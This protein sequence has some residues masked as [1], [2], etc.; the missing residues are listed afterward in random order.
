VQQESCP[1]KWDDFFLYLLKNQHWRFIDILTGE[2]IDQTNAAELHHIN[3]DKKDNN[4]SNLVYI[5]KKNHGFITSAQ[6]YWPELAF[7]F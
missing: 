6:K 5:L 2:S 1:I 7:F 4:S 3:R